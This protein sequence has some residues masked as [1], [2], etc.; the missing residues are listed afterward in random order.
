MMLG[1]RPRAGPGGAQFSRVDDGGWSVLQA[2]VRQGKGGMHRLALQVGWS[3][4][5]PRAQQGARN[6]LRGGEAGVEAL[7][8]SAPTRSAISKESCALRHYGVAYCPCTVYEHG[9]TSSG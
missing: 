7:K 8:A 4:R 5:R 1:G 2:G 3:V 9:D 6:G